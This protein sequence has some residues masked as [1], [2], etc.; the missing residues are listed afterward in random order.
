MPLDT[1]EKIVSCI[2]AFLELCLIL[3]IHLQDII[4]WLYRNKSLGCLILMIYFDN[5][6]PVCIL[7]DFGRKNCIIV[8]GFTGTNNLL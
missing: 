4:E 1:R 2:V 7:S 8:S 6:I 3:R 5:N